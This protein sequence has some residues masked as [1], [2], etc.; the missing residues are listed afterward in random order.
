[1]EGRGLAVVGGAG[2][3]VARTWRSAGVADLVLSRG[4]GSGGSS[5]EGE[6]SWRDAGVAAGSVKKLCL[7]PRHC[8]S[9]VSGHRLGASGIRCGV[10]FSS[11]L[12]LSW[13]WK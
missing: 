6:K 12:F 4:R 8:I 3:S 2:P 9:K 1:M 5:L 13:E 11:K 10:L 7:Y